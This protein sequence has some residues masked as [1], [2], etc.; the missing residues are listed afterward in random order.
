MSLSSLFVPGEG[1]RDPDG[2]A[3]AGE[4]AAALGD[5]LQAGGRGVAA[6]AG[7]QCQR[8]LLAL[9]EAAQQQ[10]QVL[11]LVDQ[12]LPETF[13]AQISPVHALKKRQVN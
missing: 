1:D 7:D 12:S 8:G 9:L 3:E 4:A 2:G 13:G 6:H 5:G 10:Q 11:L